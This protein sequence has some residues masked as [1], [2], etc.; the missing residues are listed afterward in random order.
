MRRLG[1]RDNESAL[2]DALKQGRHVQLAKEG[3][4]LRIGVLPLAVS[5]HD[6]IGAGDELGRDVGRLALEHAQLPHRKISL[7]QRRGQIHGEVLGVRVALRLCGDHEQ[8][9]VLG[10]LVAHGLGQPSTL[11]QRGKPVH[12]AN[13][14][15]HRIG[16]NDNFHGDLLV[17][18]PPGAIAGSCSFGHSLS[19][20]QNLSY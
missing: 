2:L 11:P 13:L 3:L 4:T 16:C 5:Q 20:Q 10:P 15:V 19:R 6:D 17:S 1:K 14:V 8:P 7:H 18:L 12:P 9:R